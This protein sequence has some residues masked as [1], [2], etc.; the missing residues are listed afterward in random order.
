MNRVVSWLGSRAAPWLVVIIGLALAAPALTAT[1]T[2]DDH[3]HR[4][5]SR[6]A[7]GIDGLRTRPLDLFVFAKSSA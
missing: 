3:L 4:I 1:F 7:P 5:N 2:A 6:A